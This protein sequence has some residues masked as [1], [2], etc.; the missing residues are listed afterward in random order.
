MGSHGALAAFDDMTVVGG[1]EEDPTGAAGPCQQRHH[2]YHGVGA[3]HRAGRAGRVPG[4]VAGVVDAA[5]PG[6]A[7]ARNPRAGG[8]GPRPP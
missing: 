8:G 4:A 7:G 6:P 5:A 3:P 2:V 1:E